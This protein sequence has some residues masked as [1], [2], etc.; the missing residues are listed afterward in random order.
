MKE[1]AGMAQ[2]RQRVARA[3]E[4]KGPRGRSQEEGGPCA[5]L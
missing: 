2:A 5:G 1:K 3:R 4:E